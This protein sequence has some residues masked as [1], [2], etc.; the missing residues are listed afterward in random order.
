MFIGENDA[1]LIVLFDIYLSQAK[2][3]MMTLIGFLRTGILVLLTASAYAGGAWY[4][5]EVDVWDPPFNAER[6]RYAESYVPLDKASRSWRI[7]VSIPHLKDDY[8]GAVN[9]GLIDEA[10]RLGVGV[11]LYEAGGYGNLDTQRKQIVECMDGGADGL[12]VGAISADGLNDLVE[13]YIDQ[14]KPVIDLINGLSSPKITARSAADFWDMGNQTAQY[15]RQLHA[16]ADEPVRVAWFPGPA[17]AAWVAAGDSGFR[18]GLEGS[19]VEIVAAAHGDTGLAAQGELVEQAIGAHPDLD[20]IVGTAV[21]AESALPILRKRH[22]TNQVKVLAYYY[23]P[24]V[25][26]GIGRGRVLAATTDRQALLARIAFDQIV[27]A[28]ED[29]PFLR[30]VAPQVIVIDLNNIRD[31]DAS[32]TLPPRGFRP[33]F[34]V[35]P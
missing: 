13:R 17:G 5:V 25:H 16:T 31:F 21:T 15:L 14:G 8:W 24:G 28:L 33:I 29:K 34:S 9:F 1:E 35:N 30:R 7:C 2:E 27:R 6:K 19:P 12:I 4:P 26:R 10:R 32:T 3:Y 23:S 11:Q 22:L 18:A 20:Y